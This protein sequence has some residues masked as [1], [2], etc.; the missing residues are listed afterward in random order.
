MEL[1]FG[2]WDMVK[3]IVLFVHV[4]CAE[5]VLFSQDPNQYL[6]VFQIELY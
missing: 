1:A 4:K 3:L 2:V 5:S 6:L